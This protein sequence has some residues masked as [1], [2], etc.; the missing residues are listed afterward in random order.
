MHVSVAS[1]LPFVLLPASSSSGFHPCKMT[2][3]FPVDKPLDVLKMKVIG[4]RSKG[5]LHPALLKMERKDLCREDK[6][7]ALGVYLEALCT[8]KQNE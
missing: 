3:G 6:I 1:N 7:K 8:T 4:I 2:D 5:F